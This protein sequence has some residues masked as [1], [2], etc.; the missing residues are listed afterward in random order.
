MLHSKFGRESLPQKKK[1]P[2]KKYFFI[3]FLI[4]L[5]TALYFGLKNRQ[6]ILFHLK[7]NNY[8]VIIHTLDELEKTIVEKKEI[9]T[10]DFDSTA[11]LLT[12]LIKDNPSDSYLYYLLGRLFTIQCVLP[13][14][15]DSEKMTNILFLDYIKRYQI[16]LSF[17]IKRWEQGITLTRKALL[18]GLPEAENQK[19]MVNL[20]SLYII[21]GTSYWNLD[22]AYLNHENLKN[23]PL[24]ENIY[25]LVNTEDSPDWEFF[26]KIYGMETAEYWTGLYYLKL[27]NYPLAFYNF[28]K[29][30][31]SDSTYLRNNTNYIMGYI[32]GEQRDLNLKMYYHTQIDYDEFLRRNPW[33]LGEHNYTLRF[34]GQDV[35][36]KKFLGQYEKFVLELKE[37]L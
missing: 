9:N 22:K 16:P 17:P 19:A 34:L 7:K 14:I 29:L 31:L 27:K 13:V 8:I 35:L 2:L 20:V 32:M 23:D 37:P 18:L 33:F 24:I 4:L 25:K 30:L 1:S 28:K 10:A 5:T 15:N 3:S 6:R 21:G 11:D 26:A 36:A 12:K